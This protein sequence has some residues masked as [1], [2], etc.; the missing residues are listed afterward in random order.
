M[1]RGEGGGGIGD[2]YAQQS[3]KRFSHLLISEKEKSPQPSPPFKVRSRRCKRSLHIRKPLH[4]L[5]RLKEK[6]EANSSWELIRKCEHLQMILDMKFPQ[7][8]HRL[9]QILAYI[10]FDRESPLKIIHYSATKLNLCLRNQHGPILSP[11]EEAAFAPLWNKN[12]AQHVCIL[13]Q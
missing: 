10:P 4:L 8:K 11:Q 2:T 5:H 12:T 9:N 1:K 6:L 13:N 7:V 3:H